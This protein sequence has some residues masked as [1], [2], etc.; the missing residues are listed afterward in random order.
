MILSIGCEWKKIDNKSVKITKDGDGIIK[1]EIPYINDTIID[2]IAKY[3][4]SKPNIISDEIS[5]LNGIKNGWHKHYREDGSIESI[6]KWKNALQD[7][8]T[9]WFYEDGKTIK[10]ESFWIKG[11]PYGMGKWYYRN[12]KLRTYDI[13]DFDDR[14]VYVIQYDSI[15]N[16]NNEDGVSFSPSFQYYYTDSPEIVINKDS[17]N[18]NREVGIKITASIIPNS[19]TKITM[20][21][22]KTSK[23]SLCPIKDYTAMYNYTFSKKGIYE[24][25]TIGEMINKDDNLISHDTIITTISIK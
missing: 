8:K 14:I 7:G 17:I 5:F 24:F 2:G 21:L 13:T 16:K 19:L 4:Y 6:I 3:Y 12:G 11:K 10:S 9:Y 1:S 23:L 22:N 18:I 20:G 25:V 15:G